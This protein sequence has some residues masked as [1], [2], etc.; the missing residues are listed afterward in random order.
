MA[1][2]K[3]LANTEISANPI[4]M[5]TNS[6]SIPA[7]ALDWMAMF[8]T[9]G[10]G[11]VASVGNAPSKKALEKILTLI[12]QSLFVDSAD[13]KARD[14]F[15]AIAREATNG[16][17]EDFDK[18]RD[19]A[20]VL[21]QHLRQ[22]AASQ[23]SS[24]SGTD[25]VA[26][27]SAA[28]DAGSTQDILIN[29]F[30]RSVRRSFYAIA[31]SPKLDSPELPEKLPFLL[32][33]VFTDHF[34]EILKQKFF[35]VLVKSFRGILTQANELE[36]NRREEFLMSKLEGRKQQAFLMETWQTVWS[37]LIDEKKVPKKPMVKA[38][39]VFKKIL[40]K[41]DTRQ[42]IGRAELTIEQWQAKKAEIEAA[43]VAGLENWQDICRDSEDYLPPQDADM[44]ILR[45]MFGRSA[46]AL[47]KQMTALT[48]IATQGG[49]VRAFENYIQARRV[50][51][52]FLAVVYR[53]PDL[54]L[55][56]RETDEEDGTS[57]D[58]L[59]KSVFKGYTASNC[60]QT[61]P[62]LYRYV[63]SATA[64]AG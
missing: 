60:E 47:E 33:P 58:P 16:E 13:T 35:P 9:P 21:L 52:S 2:E 27:A 28:T 39:G 42:G 20:V 30:T 54:F 38:A 62:L 61:F 25:T 22:Y 40:G 11:L 17:L 19:A 3:V 14:N 31:A 26:A 7:S 4:A 64:K 32:S 8:D 29:I 63:L 24:G 44:V 55:K 10:T 6:K 37:D 43:N 15:L 57:K 45:D 36:E 48:Q 49:S 12:I 1:K 56:A 23:M 46:G 50:D 5:R 53:H 34:V 59:I 18:S 41:M 51:L